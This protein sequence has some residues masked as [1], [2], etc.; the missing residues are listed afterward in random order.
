MNGFHEVRIEIDEVRAR[1]PVIRSL[2]N[3]V[4]E[5]LGL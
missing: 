2:I 5:E 1:L 4:K 3:V